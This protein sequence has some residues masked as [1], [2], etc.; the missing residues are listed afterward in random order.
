MLGL[1]LPVRVCVCVCVC[2]CECEREREVTGSRL[3]ATQTV[4][5]LCKAIAGRY[6]KDPTNTASKRASS[7]LKEA[8]LQS[9]IQKL[10]REVDLRV[11]AKRLP[12]SSSITTGNCSAPVYPSY[13]THAPAW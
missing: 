3:T 6:I 11:A 8:L 12:K 13:Y 2:V 7:R 5:F 1:H 10:D 4:L 9:I